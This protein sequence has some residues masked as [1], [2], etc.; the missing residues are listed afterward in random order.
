QVGRQNGRIRCGEQ[1]EPRR[2][3]RLAIDLRLDLAAFR[4]PRAQ[5]RQA[6]HVCDAGRFGD[7]RVERAIAADG[8]L[9]VHGQVPRDATQLIVH[10]QLERVARRDV[11]RREQR[12]DEERDEAECED[13]A[14]AEDAEQPSDHRDPVAVALNNS[15]FRNV[16]SPF[17]TASGA[18]T[19]PSRALNVTPARCTIPVERPLIIDRGGTSPSSFS[20]SQTPMKPSLPVFH[21]DG[22]STF[23]SRTAR[24]LST[25]Y[26]GRYS[27][28]IA[29][30]KIRP[31]SESSAIWRSR[32][33]PV[34]GPAMT[35]FGATSPL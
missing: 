29:A 27:L 13:R 19:S 31:V 32:V 26:G 35:R 12:T 4:K 21:G 5:K 18:I 1:T 16:N 25:S 3:E 15:G 11:H 28:L 20:S 8:A 34:F 24:G 10:V 17:H 7:V 14:P 9:L 23:G 22:R 33:I 6:F 2:G 30:T